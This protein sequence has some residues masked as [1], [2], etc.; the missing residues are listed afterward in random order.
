MRVVDS[1]VAVDHLRGHAPAVQLL[2]RLLA[3]GETLVSSEVVRF[4]L[5]AG[6]RRDEETVLEAFFGGLDWTSVTEEVARAAA[7]L[8]QRYR[9]SHSD[10]GAAD[11]LIAATAEVLDAPLL[12]RN[13]R[14]F[15][16][17]A[18]LEPPY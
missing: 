13:A 10:V 1:S 2:D 11:Y 7:A 6:V 5:L 3:G 8:A 16:M 15:P 14:H 4:E 17:F 9:G 12:T 18:D